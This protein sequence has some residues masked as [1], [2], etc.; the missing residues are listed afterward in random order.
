MP[1]VMSEK[2]LLVN[3]AS[4]EVSLWE[5]S[6][7]RKSWPVIPASIIAE[8]WSTSFKRERPGNLPALFYPDGITDQL[9]FFR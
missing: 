1:L 8:V 6:R 2:Y 9:G 7:K 4:F 5:N 3:T